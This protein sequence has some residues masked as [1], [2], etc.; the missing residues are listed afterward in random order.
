VSTN[1]QEIASF[2]KAGNDLTP[3]LA[4][5]VMTQILEG[6][7]NEEEI[8]EF[9]LALKTKGES[10]TDI[11]LL[12]SQL[13]RYAL[14]VS[15]S[16]RAVDPVGTGGDGKNTVNIS[17]SSAIV[18]TA[19]G[20][21]VVK[22]GS[23][24]ASSKSGAADVLSAL[25]VATDL[26]GPEVEKCVH[27]YGIGFM[28]ATTFHSALRHAAPARKAL[29]VPTVF[30]ILGPLANPA[31]P[32]VIALGVAPIEKLPV[33]AK[34]IADRGGEGFA[35]RGDDGIDELTIATTSTVIQINNG[36]MQAHTF[37]PEDIGIERAPLSA[38]VGGT[39]DVNATLIRDVFSGAQG[40]IRDAILLNSAIA[41][42]A[43]KGDFHLGVTQQIANGYVLAQQAI[44]SGKAF[45]LLENW[46]RFTQELS[47]ANQPK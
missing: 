11:A 24:A 39:P 10:A 23:I 7:A 42:A 43:F 4:E 17:T 13:L 21:R 14:P 36:E 26:T 25:G 8:K 12:V 30:N 46:G 40:P 2:L 1:W 44:D 47:P 41:I 37:D 16:E 22:H 33:M 45:D 31:Q 5:E 18:T 27:K 20:A 9:L 35:F 28:K 3:A 34:V 6:Q 19:A 29:G 15:I 38:L 32:K